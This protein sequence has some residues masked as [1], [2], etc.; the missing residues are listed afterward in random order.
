MIDQ[1]TS[2]ADIRQNPFWQE[3]VNK[4]VILKYELNPKNK[5]L[6][7]W[8]VNVKHIENEVILSEDDDIEV[9]EK[10]LKEL[11]NSE[12]MSHQILARVVGA[13]FNEGGMLRRFIGGILFYELKD[14]K[15]APIAR[16]NVLKY[17][18]DKNKP[19]RRFRMTK[20]VSKVGMFDEVV[21]ESPWDNPAS[22]FKPGLWAYHEEDHRNNREYSGIL[23]AIMLYAEVKIIQNETIRY[24]V[25][26][27]NSLVE[28]SNDLL[29]A[30]AK[31][32]ISVHFVPK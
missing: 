27:L 15:W 10:K 1:S 8:V 13:D 32:K 31:T 26:Y 9:R 22:D 30:E 3:E 14:K 24:P 21:G 18:Q 29:N 2:D 20:P 12:A 6:Y 19:D 16:V 7:F 5:D 25:T 23:G 11:E 4:Y 28:I 17:A